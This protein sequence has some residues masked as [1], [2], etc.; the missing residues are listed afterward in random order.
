MKKQQENSETDYQEVDPPKLAGRFWLRMKLYEYY[1]A[2]YIEELEKAFLWIYNAPLEDWDNMLWCIY[3]PNNQTF[4]KPLEDAKKT[5][6]PSPL[7]R[8]RKC[9]GRHLRS[10]LGLVMD[11]R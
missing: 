2:S 7:T 3:F 1:G 11:R 9:K 6:L 4:P 10:R 8:S 5:I